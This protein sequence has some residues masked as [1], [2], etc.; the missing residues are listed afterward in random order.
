MNLRRILLSRAKNVGILRRMYRGIKERKLIAALEEGLEHQRALPKAAYLQQQT[1]RFEPREIDVASAA[2]IADSPSMHIYFSIERTG[3]KLR[4][5]D[6]VPDTNFHTRQR[7]LATAYG[8]LQPAAGQ[9]LCDLG[10][11]NGY[12]S[13][14]AAPYGFQCTVV[15]PRPEHEQ[16]FGFIR[17]Q[18]GGSRDVTF[19]LGDLDTVRERSFDIV[20]TQGLLYH[21]YD[22]LGFMKEVH[23]IAT[24]AVILETELSGEGPFRNLVKVEDVGDLR[25]G[26]G[27]LAGYPGYGA[28]LALVRA[29]GFRRT[30]RIGHPNDE[31]D[32]HGYELGRR[33][34]LLCFK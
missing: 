1:G 17:D 24:K 10:G 21:L 18:L 7:M 4:I 12:Y 30:V 6:Q 27:G 8:L 33:I 28:V 20:M 32:L 16:Q 25:M 26:T 13:F 22:H 19:V 3:D 2:G 15:D 31:K 34:M 29:A 23:R 14:L 5:T 11:S 9:T